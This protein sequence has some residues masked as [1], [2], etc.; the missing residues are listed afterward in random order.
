MVMLSPCDGWVAHLCDNV[1]VTIK[2][3][4]ATGVT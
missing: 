4:A 1:A 2:M 3:I